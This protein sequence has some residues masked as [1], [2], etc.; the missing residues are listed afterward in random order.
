MTDLTTGS[1]PVWVSTVELTRRLSINR[2]RVFELKA[3][4]VF[5][6]GD[7]YRQDGERCLRWD[8]LAVDQLLRERTATSEEGA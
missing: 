6:A 7:H 1:L 8:L 3:A 2:N 4:G 5:R